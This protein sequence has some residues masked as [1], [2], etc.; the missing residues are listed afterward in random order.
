MAAQ[1]SHRAL[2]EPGNSL[3]FN[4]NMI[5]GASDHKNK[6]IVPLGIV[7]PCYGKTSGTHTH[8]MESRVGLGL[9]M[10]RVHSRMSA[11]Y[12]CD[13]LH[14]RSAPASCVFRTGHGASPADSWSLE[15][16][17]RDHVIQQDVLTGAA[18]PERGSEE[19]PTC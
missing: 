9:Y 4:V 15:T 12:I 2:A 3:D 7:V 1:I 17:N 8:Q 11:L 5:F 18:N 10:L 19:G 6:I 16:H 14:S 13:V